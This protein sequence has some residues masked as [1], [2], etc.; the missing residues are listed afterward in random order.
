MVRGALWYMVQED[1]HGTWCIVVHGTSRWSWYMMHC[2]TWYKKMVM[3]H[4][5]LWYMVQEDGHGTWC[6]VVHGTSK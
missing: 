1:G 6:I 2:G 4:G 5:A 3:V